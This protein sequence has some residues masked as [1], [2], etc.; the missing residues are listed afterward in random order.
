MLICPC[1]YLSKA[2]RTRED[3]QGRE[4]GSGGKLCTSMDWPGEDVGKYCGTCAGVLGQLAGAL[5]K[6]MTCLARGICR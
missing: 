1:A 6:M 5:P 3:W 4:R 2:E